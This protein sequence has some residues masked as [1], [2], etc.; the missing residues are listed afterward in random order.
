MSIIMIEMESDL[1]RSL[2]NVHLKEIN[3]Y[4][5]YQKNIFIS[6]LLVPSFHS[7]KQN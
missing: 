3:V 4:L 5:Y 2:I 7:L 6:A 1:H